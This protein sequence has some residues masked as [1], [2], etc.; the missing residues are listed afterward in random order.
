MR[1]TKIVCVM[2]MSTITTFAF[3]QQDKELEKYI[4]QEVKQLKK[5]GWK[6]PI[7]GLP[8]EEQLR[9]AIK[10]QREEDGNHQQKYV[11]GNAISGGSFYD[12]AKMQATE[13]AKAELAGNIAT[14]LTSAV[15]TIVENKQI[16]QE[17][18]ISATEIIRKG[19]STVS[20]RLGTTIPLIE[21]YRERKDGNVEVQIRLAY[22]KKKALGPDYEEPGTDNQFITASLYLGNCYYNGDGVKNDINQA[23]SWYE[24]AAEHG[25][26]V[27][28]EKVREIKDEIGAVSS[29]IDWLSTNDFVTNQNYELKVGIKSKS[30]IKNV[31]VIIN[32]KDFE[33]TNEQDYRGINAVRNDNYDMILNRALTLVPGENHI[34]VKV[35]NA[36]GVTTADRHVTF[37]TQETG[38]EATIHWLTKNDLVNNKEYE[39]K[40]GINSKSKIQDVNVTLNGIKIDT[41]N[42]GINAVK[43]DGYDMLLSQIVTLTPGKNNIKISVRNA[44]DVTTVDKNVTYSILDDDGE[45]RIAL[46]IG[47]SNY[48]DSDKSL[49]NPQND[50]T[51]FAAKLESLG[52]RIILT[53]DAD[54]RT[55]KERL[56]EFGD[57]A[58]NCDVALFYYAGH[59]IQSK[60]INYLIPVDAELKS[61]GYVEDECINANRILEKMED[62]RCKSKI[63]ILDACRNN[64]FVRSWHRGTTTRGLS[65]MDAPEGTF[66]AYATSP[67]NVAQDGEGRNSPYT[68]ALIKALDIQN[69]TLED[70]FKRVLREVRIKTNKQQTPW[71]ASSFEGDFYFNKKR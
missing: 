58:Q 45:K 61:E 53:T 66:I 21:M 32:G 41:S 9:K 52:F 16:S 4:K 29:T 8:I 71:T 13:L 11:F 67:G 59:G 20:Q 48:H 62:S 56:E 35:T 25:S 1:L 5:D 30:V 38:N 47:N 26:K 2:L 51:D 70:F 54:K 50:A 42:R 44:T 10:L 60:G 28:K 19:A 69:L 49:R 18:A 14:S 22:D 46:I 39:L 65:G 6:V 34:V 12:A 64:P 27:A 68:E 40:I 36:A 31:Q 43:N 7:G 55:I 63:I 33:K 37:K 3:S 15:N 24:I 57:L 17:Q 23:L